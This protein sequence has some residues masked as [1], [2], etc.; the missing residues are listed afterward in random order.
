MLVE[1]GEHL[2]KTRLDLRGVLGIGADEPDPVDHAGANLVCD[3]AELN[4]TRLRRAHARDP[5]RRA[6]LVDIA[7]PAVVK[8]PFVAP[9][10][11]EFLS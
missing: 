6:D 4:L 11:T 7:G 9:L 3:F 2:T 10:V 8:H 1:Q 5:S